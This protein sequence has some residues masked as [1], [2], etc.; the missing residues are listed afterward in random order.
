MARLD[1]HSYAD[2]TQ[3]LTKSFDWR[4]HVDFDTHVLTCEITLVFTRP[5][6]GQ[7]LDLDTRGLAID[8]VYG[9]DGAPLA[10]TLHEAEPILGRRLA[11]DVPR[12]AT[13]VRVAYRTSPEASALQ[14][15]TPEQ[16]L[17]K[18]HPYLFS[19]CQA[20]HAR[21]VIPCQDTPSIRQ[22]YTASLDVPAALRGVMAAAPLG[23]EPL[24]RERAVERFE[25]P[26]PIPPYLFAFAVGDLAS[27]DLSPRARVWA[28]PAQLDAAAWELAVLDDQLRAAESLFG[29]YDWERCDVLVM[30]PSFP[31]GGMENPRLTFLT[32]SL[33]AGDRSLM[34]VL[35]HELAHSWTG[36]LVT[37]AN[38]EHFWL[39]E[40]FTVFAER[41][42]VEVLEGPDMGA[43]HAALGYERLLQAFDQLADHPELTKL[44]TQLLGVDPDEAFSVVP[45]EKGYLFLKSLEAA[46][47]KAKFDA[48]L[49]TWLRAHRFGVATTDDFLALVERELPGLLAQVDAKAWIDGPGLPARHY[50][51]ESSRL[52]AVRALA[53]AA[54]VP[55]VDVAARWT[56]AEWQLYLEAMPKPS[57]VEVCRALDATFALT[58]ATNL[59]IAVSWLVLAC[60][61]GYDAVHPRVVD[62]L[63]GIGRM[64]YLKPL[65]RA[66]ARRDETKPLARE[67][68][69]R[70]EG[71]YHP[72]ARQVV[73]TLL[74]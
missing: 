28:E 44:R 72:I 66:L 4:A 9:P 14:W 13:S 56:P 2:D 29:P 35:A 31:Y 64:K 41:R 22:T 30:P 58:R 10:H 71:R 40:G 63:G 38:A 67:L 49:D 68:F 25:M 1:P 74:A 32:P 12:G 5:A 61:S 60:E 42:I 21:S 39:N 69:A 73:R 51:P 8:G 17:G 20:I 27:R 54:A 7:R 37:N 15:L 23:R 26:Q 45:Y 43:L 50:Q 34:S 46:A 52:D 59:E 16:T 47:G 19:Q 62:V 70:F 36:N 11:I 6:E 57:S 65:Y 3:P 55:T 24:A 33:L 48:L 18:K 53:R